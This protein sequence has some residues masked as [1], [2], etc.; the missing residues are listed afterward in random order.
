MTSAAPSL[1][2]GEPVVLHGGT[3]D[4]SSARSAWPQVGQQGVFVMHSGQAH[5]G[6][7]VAFDDP[8]D[9]PAGI[10]IETDVNDALP[11]AKRRRWLSYAY[12]AEV[13]RRDEEGRV[14]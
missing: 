1:P 8:V 3:E 12:I 5:R 13:R 7:V 10:T 9:L 14:P 2:G 4:V 11:K 6:T